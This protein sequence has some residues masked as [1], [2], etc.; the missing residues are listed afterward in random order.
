MKKKLP[1]ALALA[2]VVLA[3]GLGAIYYQN[4]QVP[5]LGVRDGKLKPLGSKPNDVSS[6]TDNLAKKVEPLEFKESQEA[7]LLALKSAI[8]AI[9]GVE[10]KEEREDYLY[11]VF[12]S[13]FMKFRDDVE[14]WLDTDNQVVHSRSAARA[15]YS[16]MGVNR[17][18]YD[19]LAAFYKEL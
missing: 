13:R 6:Q 7:T 9:G 11:V 17:K 14:F 4:S 1:K 3:T 12:S 2:C 19:K 8:N 5:N 16:D 15:G 18:R 10:F